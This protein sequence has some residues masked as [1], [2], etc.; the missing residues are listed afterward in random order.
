MVS[1]EAREEGHRGGLLADPMGFGKTAITIGLLSE[2][3]CQ[4]P[5]ERPKGYI[6]CPATLILSPAHLV[7]QWEDEFFKFL[8]EEVEL[9]RPTARPKSK[10]LERRV[11]KIPAEPGAWAFAVAENFVIELSQGLEKKQRRMAFEKRLQLGDEIQEMT[12][13]ANEGESFEGLQPYGYDSVQQLSCSSG[14][15]E[16]LYGHGRGRRLR[17]TVKRDPTSRSE[18]VR[19]A[20]PFKILSIMGDSGLERLRLKDLLAPWHVVLVSTSLLG[21]QKHVDRIRRLL[22]A[23]TAEPAKAGLMRARQGQLRECVESW[24]QRPCQLLACLRG[25]KVL[26]ELLWWNRLVLDEF[27]EAG[28]WSYRV[29]EI[30]KSMGATHRWGLSGTPPLDSTESLLEV[31]Q[32]LWYATKGLPGG[33]EEECREMVRDVVRRNGSEVLKAWSS[34]SKAFKV[35]GGRQRL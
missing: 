22:A 14:F 19:G 20:G 27:H 2:S 18:L 26:L 5:A 28:A 32:L 25:S 34:D 17:V 10:L 29:R 24:H 13:E 16:F 7:S 8:G 30:A 21:S 4:V 12:V 23:W 9:H 35:S 33:V 11:I 1:Q 15:R 6:S 3:K 31:A